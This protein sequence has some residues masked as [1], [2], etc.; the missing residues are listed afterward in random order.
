MCQPHLGRPFLPQFL[1]G[2]A[3]SFCHS[4]RKLLDAQRSNRGRAWYVFPALS[5]KIHRLDKIARSGQP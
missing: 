5:R 1:Q 2:T 4:Q 3:A